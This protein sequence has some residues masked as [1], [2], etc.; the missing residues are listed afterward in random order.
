MV[1]DPESFQRDSF[2]TVGRRNEYRRLEKAEAGSKILP[3][4][5]FEAIEEQSCSGHRSAE[6]L[7]IHV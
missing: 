2:Y 7:A 3:P 6:R 5:R 1:I 4:P